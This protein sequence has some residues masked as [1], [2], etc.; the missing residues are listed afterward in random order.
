MASKGEVQMKKILKKY[1]ELSKETKA[2][3]W[4]AMCNFLN[5][6][7]SM[8]VIPI[9]T[10]LLIT[11]EYGTYTVFQSWLN[12]LVVVA[13]LEISRGHYKVGITKYE[14]DVQRYTTSVLGLS[15]VVTAAFIFAVVCLP[16][17]AVAAFELPSYVILAMLGYLLVYPAWEFWAIQQRF[18]Y[19]YRIMVVATL[20]VAVLSPVVGIVG[21][22]CFGMQSDA[23]IF[24][25][26]IVQG[27]IALIIYVKIVCKNRSLC[28]PKY[29]KEV[30]RFN[31]ALIPYLLSTTILNQADRIM[32]GK[33]VGAT[34][35]AIYSVAYS[36]AMIML[37]VNTAISDAFVPWIYR[38]LKLKKYKAIEPTTNKML[39]L[40]AGL[41][42]LVVLLAPEVL[43]FFAPAEYVA[44]LGVIPPVTASVYFMFIFQRYINVEVYYGDTLK[45]SATSIGVAI[46]NVLLNYYC[47]ARWGY[48][49]AGYTTLFCYIVFCVA[50]YYNVKRICLKNGMENQIF[51][52]RTVVVL[53]VCFL[54]LIFMLMAAYPYSWIRYML[55]LV[56]AICAY[57]KRR[58]IMELLRKK[59]KSNE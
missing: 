16:D 33:M 51:T 24:S 20:A 7:I 29:W 3:L 45:I 23:A 54:L 40:V 42:L 6:G 34:E 56:L 47:I 18:T 38:N 22:T 30:F 13:T 25:K 46:L 14:D 2:A 31:V 58:D 19:K 4:F 44:A 35:A 52:S 59:R 55:A 50:H 17:V 1:G 27:G 48:Y 9:Y 10:R 43:A 11:A 49:A 32:I 39:V 12:I 36:V 41:N 5:K 21:I 37:L 15:N 28:V 26:L 8:I 53:S 57:W